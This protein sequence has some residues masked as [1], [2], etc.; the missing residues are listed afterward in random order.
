MHYIYHARSSAKRWGGKS[1]DYVDIHKWIDA[2]HNS[3]PDFRHRA[4][5]HHVEGIAETEQKFGQIITNSFGKAVPVRLIAEQHVREDCMGSIPTMADWFR[6]IMPKRW[7]T[8][9][10]RDKG[11]KA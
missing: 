3:V 11:A 7:M 6:A 5:R 10:G 9:P 1:D 2:S 8:K 4:L